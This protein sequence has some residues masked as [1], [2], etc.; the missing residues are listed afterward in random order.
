LSADGKSK[1]PILLKFFRKYGEEDLSRMAG[2]GL[3]VI[4]SAEYSIFVIFES[5]M[6]LHRNETLGCFNKKT[7]KDG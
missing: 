2:N 5:F 3:T 4:F 1:D 7:S 6:E